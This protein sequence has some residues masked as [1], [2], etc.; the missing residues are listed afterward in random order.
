MEA[1]FTS[2]GF[3]AG[4]LT[5]MSFVPQALHSW[6]SRS[7]GDFSWLWIVCFSAGLLLWF[8]YGLYL[9]NWPMI[10]A[11]SVTLL[12]VVPVVIVKLRNPARKAT[13]AD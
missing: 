8:T 10:L 13:A 1:L 3:A 5:T 12:L 9:H 4:F 6:K 2:L 11:N 7:A